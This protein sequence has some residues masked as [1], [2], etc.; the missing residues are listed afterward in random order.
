MIEAGYVLA[1]GEARR[2]NG[3]KL[4]ALV[5]GEASIARVV[6]ALRRAGARE[7]Y[8]ATVSEERC[9][10]YTAVAGLDGCIYDPPIPCR[11]PGAALAAVLRDAAQ[12]GYRTVAVA[13]GDMPWLTGEA[14]GRLASMPPSP[15]WAAAPLHAEGFLESLL[16][17]YR[18]PYPRGLEELCRLRGG[19][20]ASDPLRLA[21]GGL[22]L[23]GSRLLSPWATVFAH[24]NTR[25][26]LRT[27]AAKNRLGDGVA[28][29]PGP[30]L[31]LDDPCRS[32]AAEAQVYSL[33]GARQLLRQAL[34]DLEKLCSS[35]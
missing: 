2:F 14:V 21:P 25:E 24:I 3:D 33:I 18:S 28:Q 29:L 20:R 16:Q 4:L 17:V 1:G 13:P 9:R 31:R 15:G 35:G 34:E 12:R 11:G 26:A 5:D 23:A 32:L 30:L 27:R 10:I 6:D 22:V 7:V 19:L 8:A